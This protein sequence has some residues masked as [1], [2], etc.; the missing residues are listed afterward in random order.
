[1][2]VPAVVNASWPTTAVGVTLFEAALHGP[3]PV[4]FVALTLNVYAVPVAKP[5]TVIGEEAAVPVMQLGVEVAVYPVIPPA[6]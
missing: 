5:D 1:V 3:V 6:G 4:A 2:N